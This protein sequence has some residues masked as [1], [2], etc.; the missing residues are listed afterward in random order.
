MCSGVTLAVRRGEF[1][2]IYGTSGGGKT[3]MLNVI[4]TIDKPTKG[5]LFLFG[6]R[7]TSRTKDVELAEIRSRK[8]YA[9][10]ASSDAPLSPHACV[11]ARF[12]GALCSRRSICCRR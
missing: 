11:L 10:R 8:M 2:T 5:Q 7:I 6:S 3:T 1:V 9:R 12:A 4:G